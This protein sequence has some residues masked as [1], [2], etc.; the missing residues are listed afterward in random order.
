MT[1]REQQI[2]R[3]TMDDIPVVVKIHNINNPNN[4]MTVEMLEAQE[5]GRNSEEILT[6][7]VI[8]QDGKVVAYGDCGN[9]NATEAAD[10]YHMWITVHPDYGQQGLGVALLDNFVQITKADGR[11]KLITACAEDQARAIDWL[12]KRGFER[13]GKFAELNLDV[14]SFDSSFCE[15]V[16]R[17]STYSVTS[18]HEEQKVS[19]DVLEVLYQTLVSPLMKEMIQ[20]GGA[21]IDPSFEEYKS[22]FLERP[23]SG[24][25]VKR[26][27]PVRYDKDLVW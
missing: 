6:Q 26:T 3:F 11:E 5:R 7:V 20:P 16:D 17:A 21:T 12:T 25:S 18:I 14:A 4:M 10:A 13:I 19:P 9:I 1:V 8:E 24:E 2:R 23:D 27:L 15:D 22:M